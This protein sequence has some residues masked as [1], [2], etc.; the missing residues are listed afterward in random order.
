MLIASAC[1]IVKTTRN[2]Q[3]VGLTLLYG[4]LLDYIYSTY[5]KWN[6]IIIETRVYEQHLVD[7]SSKQLHDFSYHNHGP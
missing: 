7:S 6:V 2:K 5:Q 3:A 1:S 4:S